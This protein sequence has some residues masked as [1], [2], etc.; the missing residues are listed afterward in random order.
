VCGCVLDELCADGA[1]IK[2][3]DCSHAYG[4]VP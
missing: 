1:G 2:D 4:D 3:R